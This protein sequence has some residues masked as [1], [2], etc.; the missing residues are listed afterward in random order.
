MAKELS[1][2]AFAALMGAVFAVLA[3]LGLQFQGINWLEVREPTL[4]EIWT[5]RPLT[6]VEYIDRMGPDTSSWRKLKL[7]VQASARPD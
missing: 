2:A 1:Q 7:N 3:L 5:P 4:A 6:P